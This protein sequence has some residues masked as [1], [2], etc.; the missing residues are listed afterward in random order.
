MRWL[1]NTTPRPTAPSTMLSRPMLA[2]MLL[3]VIVG[4]PV[5]G[6][7][8]IPG[9]IA[10]SVWTWALFLVLLTRINQ[11][12][13]FP[14]MLCLVISTLGECGLSLL[15]GL[16][17]YWLHNVPF[18]VPPGHVLLFALGLTLA[19]RL[20]QWA[21]GLVAFSA[22][23]YGAAA[24]LTST[25][26]LSVAL[27]ILFLA[28]MTFGS[29]RRLYAT[30]FVISLLMELYGTWIGNWM[31][32]PEVPGLPLS[33]ANPPLCVGGLYCALDLCVVNADR[34]LRRWR[35]SSGR[36]VEAGSAA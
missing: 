3:T 27:A 17:V 30:M 29:N 23:G 16:Y 12:L 8:G 13:R 20:P 4:L 31:W 18:F 7:G 36:V 5:D 2:T 33:S 6:F 9:Q 19:P 28:F 25:D 26:T 35:R 32:V 34:A 21:I 15:W 1:S 24:F 14:L 10:V 11:Q 22:A